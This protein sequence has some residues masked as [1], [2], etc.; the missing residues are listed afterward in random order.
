MFQ[1]HPCS[2]ALQEKKAD[3]FSIAHCNFHQFIG[4][5]TEHGDIAARHSEC[6]AVE[7]IF[8]VTEN[9]YLLANTVEEMYLHETIVYPPQLLF[10]A[11]TYQI[12]SKT[13]FDSPARARKGNKEFAKRLRD[14]FILTKCPVFLL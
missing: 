12:K 14:C 5:L 4:K 1:L 8:F 9:D 2:C 13:T 6:E 7:K 11:I 10:G 3:D